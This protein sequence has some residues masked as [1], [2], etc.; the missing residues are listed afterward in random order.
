MRL[1]AHRGVL[2][3]Q[4]AELIDLVRGDHLV[5][6]PEHGAHRRGELRHVLAGSQG[7]SADRGAGPRP[8]V[9]GH[10]GT[11]PV[12]LGRHHH[13]VAT[14]DGEPDRAQAIGIDLGQGLEPG[15]RHG[16]IGELAAVVEPMEPRRGCPPCSRSRGVEP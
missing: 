12:R 8:G 9:K 2:P 4:P 3:K 6:G 11:Q 15:E 5:L 13:G 10:D 16:Q 14:S 7:P 1:V